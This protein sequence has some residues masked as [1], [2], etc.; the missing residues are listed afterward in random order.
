MAIKINNTTVI[1]NNR[2]IS[3]VGVAT[4]G[5]GSSITRINGN[6][7]IVNVGTGVTINGIT[8]NIS[9]AGIL[10]ATSINVGSVP[11]ATTGKSIAMAIVF[12]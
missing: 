6:T 4:I 11:V 9:I 12:G 5:S 10:T 1:D 7:G 2:N 3:S 8:G